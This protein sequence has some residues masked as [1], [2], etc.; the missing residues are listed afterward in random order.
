M[1]KN[2]K[3]L[4]KVNDFGNATME[5][6][7]ETIYKSSSLYHM[8]QNNEVRLDGES[9]TLDVEEII[10]LASKNQIDLTIIYYDLDKEYIS[11]KEIKYGHIVSNKEMGFNINMEDEV[12][13]N[14]PEDKDDYVF[15]F[16]NQ[17]L[18]IPRELS[19]LP[20]VNSIVK[21]NSLCDDE[22]I[23][24]WY[25]DQ[26]SPEFILNEVDYLSYRAYTDSCPYAINI[27]YLTK[28]TV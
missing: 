13:I 9:K 15:D 20:Q 2:I 12:Y 21:I 7:K 24:D 10:E 28:L 4:I 26:E 27:D 5:D 18:S 14:V 3:F 8:N 6:I 25:N 17:M 19:S 22:D 1:Q 11:K 23:L 16:L